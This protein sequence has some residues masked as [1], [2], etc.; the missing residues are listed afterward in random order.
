MFTYGTCFLLPLESRTVAFCM[1][2]FI[3]SSALRS[4][5]IYVVPSL[6][7]IP[8]VCPSPSYR[9]TPGIPIPTLPW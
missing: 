7:S 5:P 9:S 4:T 2:T 6:V 3:L 1:R 8:I